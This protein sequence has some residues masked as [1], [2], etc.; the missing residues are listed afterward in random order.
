MEELT[1]IFNETLK[2]NLKNI[3]PRDIIALVVS[4]LFIDDI[5]FAIYLSNVIKQINND[6]KDNMD[7]NIYYLILQNDQLFKFLSLKYFSAELHQ[8]DFVTFKVRYSKLMGL[9]I[10][11]VDSLLE[12][13]E[14][15]IP[16][17]I[18]KRYSIAYKNIINLKKISEIENCND[19]K[20]D[21]YASNIINWDQLITDNRNLLMIAAI[22]NNVEFINLL[23]GFGVDFNFKNIDGDTAL[24]LALKKY[25]IKS[26]LKDAT[27]K[28]LLDLGSDPNITDKDGN[29]ALMLATEFGHQFLVELLIEKKENLNINHINNDGDTALLLAIKLNNDKY[30]LNEPII[31]LLIDSGSDLN[32]TDKN[33]NNAL[34]L[35]VIFYKIDIVRLII[36]KN[37]KNSKLNLNIKLNI[38]LN[39]QLNINKINNDGYTPLSLCCRCNMYTNICGICDI[40]LK[41][42]A[43]PNLIGKNNLTI[44]IN[45]FKK[46]HPNLE[47]IEHLIKYGA[48]LNAT[49]QDGN[50][51][52]LI[53]IKKKNFILTD[54]L[55]KKYEEYQKINQNI[56]QNINLNQNSCTETLKNIKLE[57]INVDHVNNKGH[58][59]LY[60]LLKYQ[61][62]Y[63]VYRLLEGGANVN[64]LDHKG[65]NSLFISLLHSKNNDIIFSIIKSGVNI[66]HK[67]NKGNTMLHL[68]CLKNNI[69]IV[70]YFH[71]RF[72]I[73]QKN[74]KDQTPLMLAIS[75]NNTKIIKLLVQANKNIIT[76]IIN[77]NI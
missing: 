44:L 26:Y 9:Y 66:Y 23:W 20:F 60:Y 69:N 74:N 10:K 39:P 34:S 75:K 62:D 13:D 67:N 64:I 43:D 33:G 68:A 56:Y 18:Q 11:S 55:I 58:N 63:N 72:D 14:K 35:A 50:T 77:K 45:K 61:D 47:Q 49:D 53:M 71:N 73:N 7:S 27:V 8:Y 19:E 65:N 15:I 25:N 30:V 48:D 42:G 29:N 70:K 22:K 21:L 54:F 38:G 51:P 41:S 52:L 40:L 1:K 32:I 4:Y 31:K 3:I 28:L 37:N 24:S 2:I 16:K 12:V 76:D 46:P 6:N 59:A 5:K 57:N 17:H 36:N